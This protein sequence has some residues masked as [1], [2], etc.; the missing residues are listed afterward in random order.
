MVIIG[1]SF[2]A[3]S[4]LGAESRLGLSDLCPESGSLLYLTLLPRS[5]TGLRERGVA[6]L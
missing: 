6:D 3:Y 4:G 1:R 2:D 5:R